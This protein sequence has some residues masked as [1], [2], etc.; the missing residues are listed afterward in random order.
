MVNPDSQQLSEIVGDDHAHNEE[1]GS[2]SSTFTAINAQI[3]DEDDTNLNK[4]IE[5][6]EA[7]VFSCPVP[8]PATPQKRS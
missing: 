1:M 3:I 4:M 7:D 2:I 5:D 6:V 8:P